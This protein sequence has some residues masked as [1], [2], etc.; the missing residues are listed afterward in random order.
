MS[1]NCLSLCL[2]L[3]DPSEYSATHTLLPSNGTNG[4]R[5]QVMVNGNTPTGGPSMAHEQQMCTDPTR[6]SDN[7]GKFFSDFFPLCES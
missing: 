7:T 4:N 1:V 2:V 3:F 5:S 6:D